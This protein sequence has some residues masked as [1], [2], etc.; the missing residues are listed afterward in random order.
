MDALPAKA[1]T[2][3]GNL[4]AAAQAESARLI[5]LLELHGI[6]WRLPP[7]PVAAKAC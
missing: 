5:A 7:E 6:D 3:E 4:L 1:P 2:V